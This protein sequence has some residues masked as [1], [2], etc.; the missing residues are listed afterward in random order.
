VT[1]VTTE[2]MIEILAAAPYDLLLAEVQRRRG[3]QRKTYTGGVFWKT[4]NPDTSRCRCKRCTSKR[5]KERAQ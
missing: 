1:D 4:H 2:A 5:E 3:A